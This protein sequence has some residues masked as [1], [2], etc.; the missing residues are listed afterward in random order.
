[1]RM[2]KFVVTVVVLLV[3]VAGWF[4]YQRIDDHMQLNALLGGRSVYDKINGEPPIVEVAKTGNTRLI[5]LLLDMGAD[6]N[7]ED[8]LR[9]AAEGGHIDAVKLLLDHCAN[10]KEWG[11]SALRAA[12]E[13]GHIEVVK[14]LLDRG[15][16]VNAQDFE[17]ETALMAAS[18]KGHADVVKLLL[19][20]GAD[21]NAKLQY[22]GFAS[23]IT[24]LLAASMEGHA[25]VVKMLLDH[26]ANVKEW[27]GSALRSASWNGH[28]DVVKLLLDRGADVN[29]RDDEGETALMY[30]CRNGNVN[31]V[32]LLLDR[33]ADV[34]VINWWSND[35][36]TAL[37]VAKDDQIRALLK[38]HGAR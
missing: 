32:K 22:R 1:M 33:G 16:D 28:A 14:L 11:G 18:R 20:R 19:E 12:S 17:K 27:G 10:V 25:D 3:G 13:N 2:K 7:A 26:G 21:V 9:T 37:S 38:A 36:L 30:A 6:E 4:I 8:A 23:P 29:A 15:V 31:V 5:R 24:A 34:I 35:T